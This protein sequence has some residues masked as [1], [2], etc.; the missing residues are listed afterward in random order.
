[1]GHQDNSKLS[2]KDFIM[3]KMHV[4][5]LINA[6]ANNVSLFQHI[7]SIKQKANG[8]EWCNATWKTQHISYMR[9]LMNGGIEKP[10]HI[11]WPMLES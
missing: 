8:S 1:M 11:L 6:M 3:P 9:N 7:G 4:M 2:K 10:L 5:M